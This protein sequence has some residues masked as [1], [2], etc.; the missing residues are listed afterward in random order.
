VGRCQRAAL[1]IG[2]RQV[3]VSSLR[4]VGAAAGAT[5]AGGATG[6]LPALMRLA[7]QHDGEHAQ[8]PGR[9]SLLMPL[10]HVALP[11]LRKA[12]M[13]MPGLRAPEVLPRCPVI[14]GEHRVLGGTVDPEE[15]IGANE[16][17][18]GGAVGNAAD[19]TT[20]RRQSVTAGPWCQ[21]RS[22]SAIAQKSYG[23]NRK[24][25]GAARA[26]RDGGVRRRG[27]KDAPV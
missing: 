13:Q 26:S 15:P 1:Q 6:A 18:D 24:P 2:W 11:Q 19:G 16:G 14:T 4:G 20:P 21:P 27:Q 9:D 17:K 7:I 3:A 10:E 22:T 12:V 8:C 25:S 5:G 23:S